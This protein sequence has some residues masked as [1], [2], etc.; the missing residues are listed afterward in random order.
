MSSHPQLAVDPPEIGPDSTGDEVMMVVF[1][2][3][4]EPLSFH[5]PIERL[6][7]SSKG[8][9]LASQILETVVSQHPIV[10]TG[11]T[12]PDVTGGAHPNLSFTRLAPHADGMV[13]VVISDN[14][15]DHRQATSGATA[16]LSPHGQPEIHIVPDASAHSNKPDPR[17]PYI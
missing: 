8:L 17:Y 4:D 5:M 2:R 7:D 10:E 1:A 11:K 6:L 3:G 12:Q 9:S 13:H 16:L 14:P 15:E